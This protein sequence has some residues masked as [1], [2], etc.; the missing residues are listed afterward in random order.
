[1]FNCLLPLRPFKNYS[2]IF[3]FFVLKMKKNVYLCI[4]FRYHKCVTDYRTPHDS[5][6]I[7]FN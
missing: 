1:M 6:A 5:E 3:A 4:V 7:N 2:N